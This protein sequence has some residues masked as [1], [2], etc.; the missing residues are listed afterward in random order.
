MR[1]F[2]LIEVLI[3]LGMLAT[4]TAATSGM[5]AGSFARVRVRMDQSTLVD[6]LHRAQSAAMQGVCTESICHRGVSH[7]V[8]IERDRFVLFSGASYASRSA[9]EDEVIIRSS[10]SEIDGAQEFS[11]A[12]MSGAAVPEGEA[13]FRL[14]GRRLIVSVR[15]SGLIETSTLSP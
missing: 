11:F 14:D 12:R 10:D 8:R 7:G 15:A 13:V 6:T 5:S 4:V 9:A 2:T 1:C 3:L